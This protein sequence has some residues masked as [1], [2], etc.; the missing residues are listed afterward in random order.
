MIVKIETEIGK[1]I[2]IATL[3]AYHDDNSPF[4]HRGIHHKKEYSINTEKGSRQIQE[5]RILLHG[6]KELKPVPDMKVIIKPSSPYI[7]ACLKSL[8]K[9]QQSGWKTG[10]GKEVKHKEEWQEI[11]ELI[12]NFEVEV[13]NEQINMEKRK[14]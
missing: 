4:M 1:F 13:K 2:S 14:R 7:D 9:W 11:Y 8:T 10:K 12:N 5:I 3:S 6:W